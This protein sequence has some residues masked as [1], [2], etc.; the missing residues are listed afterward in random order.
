MAGVPSARILAGHFLGVFTLPLYLVGF[1]HLHA[2]LRPAGAWRSAPVVGL[3]A[4]GTLVGIFYHGSIV[5][6]ALLVQTAASVPGAGPLLSDLMSRSRTFSWPA[7][8]AVLGALVA[9][10]LWLAA[11][12]LSGRTRY[13][14]W[15]AAVNPLLLLL[16]VTGLGML[17]PAAGRFLLPAAQNVPMAVF[18]A[19]STAVLWN[20]GEEAAH[21]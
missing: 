7:Q 21:G 14:R 15:F 10:S 2:A 16:A 6:P 3:M 1:W 12:V 8:A 19:S 9:A 11:S 17:V 4:Y 5:Y 13:P 18:F 20:A